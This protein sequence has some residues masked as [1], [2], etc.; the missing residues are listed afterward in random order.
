MMTPFEGK[1]RG[2]YIDFMHHE[3]YLKT[4]SQ[5]RLKFYEDEPSFTVVRRDF[6]TEYALKYRGKVP[7]VDEH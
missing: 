3:K 2:I 5:R 4:H 1:R 6:R 7:M